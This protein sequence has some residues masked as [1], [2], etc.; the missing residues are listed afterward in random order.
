MNLW[1]DFYENIAQFSGS[2]HT[3]TETQTQTLTHSRSI[4]RKNFN[5][6]SVDTRGSNSTKFFFSVG[7]CAPL[8]L[9]LHDRSVRTGPFSVGRVLAFGL[10][11]AHTHDPRMPERFLFIY[12]VLIVFYFNYITSYGR[13]RSH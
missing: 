4:N 12:V 3:R 11:C 13:Q 5:K 1:H 7:F 2:R 10:C 6:N 9:P 8:S